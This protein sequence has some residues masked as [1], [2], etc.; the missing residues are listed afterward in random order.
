MCPPRIRAR[1][2]LRGIARTRIK[3]ETFRIHARV[4]RNKMTTAQR[5]R[6]FRFRCGGRDSQDGGRR[7]RKRSASIVRGL[8]VKNST[9]G[10][11]Q[12]LESRSVKTTACKITSALSSCPLPKIPSLRVS[13]FRESAAFESRR[14]YR[15]NYR[16]IIET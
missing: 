6:R 12:R 7:R 11:N 15:R 10:V 2:R 14:V 5:L 13:R 3:S 9:N 8:S 1:I 4:T 16:R